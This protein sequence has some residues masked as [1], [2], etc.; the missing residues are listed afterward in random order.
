MLEE[1]GKSMRSGIFST[2]VSSFLLFCETVQAA[3]ADGYGH[4]SHVTNVRFDFSD[5]HVFTTG[6]HDRGILQWKVVPRSGSGK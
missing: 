5:Q 2:W 4:S 3:F 1:R 6:G